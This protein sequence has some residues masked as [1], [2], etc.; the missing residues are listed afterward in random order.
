MATITMHKSLRSM[1]RPFTLAGGLAVR[2]LRLLVAWQMRANERA[3]LANLDDA[4]LKD[5][6]L[7][8]ADISAEACKPFWRS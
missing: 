1:E 5:M 6:G 7:S 2:I 3:A 8:R 4:A